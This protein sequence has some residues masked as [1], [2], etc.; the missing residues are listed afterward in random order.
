MLI[1]T[2]AE[3]RY[4]VN[5][6]GEKYLLEI[7]RSPDGKTFIVIEKLRKHVYEKEGEEMVW[8]QNVED[9]EEIEYDKLPQEVRVAFSS[10]TKR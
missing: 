9:I 10:A 2:N 6:K 3:G 1:K 4:V 5:R 7:R 8:E